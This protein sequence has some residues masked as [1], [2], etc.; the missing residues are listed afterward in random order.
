MAE[1]RHLH[2]TA[3][4]FFFVLAGVAT[5]ELAGSRHEVAAGEGLEVLPGAAHQLF[6]HGVESLE[7]LV[8][9]QPPSHGDR[10]PA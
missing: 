2:V 9:S 4:Q 10:V 5:I 7:F 3:R 1:N 8:I 6:N